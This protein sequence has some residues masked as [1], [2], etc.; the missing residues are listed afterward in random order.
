MDS[1]VLRHPSLALTHRVVGGQAVMFF[2]GHS[3]FGSARP[4]IISE[5]LCLRLRD[6]H[7]NRLLKT[8]LLV[9]P[10][11]SVRWFYFCNFTPLVVAIR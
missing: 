11:V 9:H 8:V 3:T 5:C 1:S 6:H 7:P 2:F 4:V 10:F